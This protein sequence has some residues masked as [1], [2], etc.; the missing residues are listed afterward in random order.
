MEALLHYSNQHG[1]LLLGFEYPDWQFDGPDIFVAIRTAY[2]GAANAGAS[3]RI[4][5]TFLRNY[6]S[7][8]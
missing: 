8:C 4:T 2:R 3:N 5:F 6:R 1:I 7:L